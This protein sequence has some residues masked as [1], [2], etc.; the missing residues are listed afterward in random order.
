PAPT[1]APVPAPLPAGT[2]ADAFL[3]FGTSSFPEASILL[4][5]NPQPWYTSPT[6]EKYFGGQQPNAQQQLDFKDAVLQDVKSTFQLSGGLAPVLTIDPNDKANHTLS[7]VSGASYGPNQNAIGITDVGNNGFGFI[8]KLGQAQSLTDLQWAVAHN[9]SH[10]LMHAFGVSVHHD[11]TGQYLDAATASWS[12]LTDPNTTFSQA[13]IDDL[14]SRRFTP[15]PTGYL[16]PQMI[17]GDLEILN[18]VPEPTTVAMW[19]VA[20]TIALMGRRRKLR[21]DAAKSLGRSL[22]AA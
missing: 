8:D 13:T 21:L 11:Q 6:V 17:D 4:T 14:R 3:N 1:P 15:V 10:E 7:V 22:G 5:G 20:A 19:G 2:T 9:V 16:G 12:M 18:P